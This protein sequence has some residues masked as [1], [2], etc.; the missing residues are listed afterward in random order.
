MIILMF[1]QI[2]FGQDGKV[3]KKIELPYTCFS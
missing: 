3:F 2:D 1:C